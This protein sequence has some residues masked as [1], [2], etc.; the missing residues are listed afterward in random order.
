MLIFTI[1]FSMKKILVKP[2]FQIGQTLKQIAS[3][4][5]TVRLPINSRDEVAELSLHFNNAMEQIGS[6]ISSLKKYPNH[7]QHR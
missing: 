1:I 4:D 5:L 3:G 2:L 6:A 7:E